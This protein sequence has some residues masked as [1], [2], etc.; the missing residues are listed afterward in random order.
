M[1]VCQLRSGFEEG[2]FTGIDKYCSWRG[3]HRQVYALLKARA[4]TWVPL[5]CHKTII[6]PAFFPNLESYVWGFHYLP[7]FVN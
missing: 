3:K 7:M 5:N 1:N 2:I 4:E 6:S